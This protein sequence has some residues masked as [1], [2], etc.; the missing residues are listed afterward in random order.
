MSSGYAN[1]AVDVFFFIFARKQNEDG[2]VTDFASFYHL[3][4]TIIGHEK[5]DILR[6]VY[7]YYNV[8]TTMTMKELMKDALVLARNENVDV[9]NALDLMQNKE[10]FEDLK[11]GAGDGHL[12]YYLYN[13]KCPEITSDETGLVLL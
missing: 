9:F 4:S 3:P 12:Q 11:F 10:V 7:A 5:H 13:W 2:N 8:P 6:A 1:S